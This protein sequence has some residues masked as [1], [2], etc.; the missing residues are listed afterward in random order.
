MYDTLTYEISGVDARSFAL[1]EGNLAYYADDGDG[2]GAER[3]PQ[4]DRG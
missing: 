3:S 4:S 2:I 1:A